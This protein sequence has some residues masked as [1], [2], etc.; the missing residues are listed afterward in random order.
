MKTALTLLMD[1]NEA[2]HENGWTRLDMHD[3]DGRMC[4]VGALCC[5][6]SG[7]PD[8][9]ATLDDLEA[10]YQDLLVRIVHKAYPTEPACFFSSQQARISQWVQYWNDDDRRT[11]NEV[12]HLIDVVIGDL[13]AETF[14]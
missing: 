4:L 12:T 2:L 10:E 8:D 3:D 9:P 13:K 14:T 6:L 11:Y 5:A 1:A 7:L